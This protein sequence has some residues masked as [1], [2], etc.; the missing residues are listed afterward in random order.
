LAKR[1]ATFLLLL[2]PAFVQAKPTPEVLYRQAYAKETGDRDPEAALALYEEVVRQSK[3]GAPLAVKAHY[4]SGECLELLGRTP[5][6]IRAYEAVV[7]SSGAAVLLE[8]DIPARERLARLRSPATLPSLVAPPFEAPAAPGLSLRWL[9]SW[10]LSLAPG[11]SIPVGIDL[12]GGDLGRSAYLYGSAIRRVT[13]W[14]GLG[15]EAGY[16]FGHR[17]TFPPRLSVAGSDE[18]DSRLKIVQVS[19]Q[20]EVGRWLAGRRLSFRPYATLGYGFYNLNQVA[21][22]RANGLRVFISDSKN[23]GGINIGAGALLKITP[24]FAAGPDLRFHH[25]FS[26]TGDLD[27]LVTTF[28]FVLLL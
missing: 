23:Y 16:G 15:L 6:A 2:L 5:E 14:L 3:S 20:I 4:R 26:P 10:S 27:F 21:A 17:L 9:E 24:S 7:A 28:R 19:P 1:F 12:L 8:L 18:G 22:Y 13:P 11:M 25:L